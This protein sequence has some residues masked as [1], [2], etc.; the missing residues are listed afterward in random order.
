MT[1]T[2]QYYAAM[3]LLV[4]AAI[5]VLGAHYI[6]IE[7]S[8]HKPEVLE[9]N[10]DPITTGRVLPPPPKLHVRKPSPKE[11][12]PKPE[13]EITFHEVIFITEREK[14]CLIRNVFYEANAEPYLGKIGVAQVTWNRVKYGKWG[15]D[16]CRVVYAPGQ[17]SWTVEVHKRNSRVGGKGWEDT[18]QAVEDF[19]NGT[20]V[21][22]LENSMF[23][24]ASYVRPNW[25][26]W[27]DRI[28][29]IG[30]HVFYELK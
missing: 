4:W 26:T 20:R 15:Q 23:F 24:H 2:R 11:E 7:Y 9:V 6:D 29:Q 21:A 14:T 3:L 19:I 16:I 17:F 30:N 25:H 10:L 22:K 27:A 5:L 18:V 8:G 28:K 12:L 13:I 1:H